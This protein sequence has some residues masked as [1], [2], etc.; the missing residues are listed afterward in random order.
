MVARF[1][2]EM[3]RYAQYLTPDE[4][5]QLHHLWELERV[6]I[7]ERKKLI[8]RATSRRSRVVWPPKPKKKKATS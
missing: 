8:Q 5:T 1:R 6:I 7:K 4:A 3:P 2:P